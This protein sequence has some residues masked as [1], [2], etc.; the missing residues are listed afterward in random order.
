MP[1]DFSVNL[2]FLF[3]DNKWSPFQGVVLEDYV[4]NVN[5]GLINE[6]KPSVNC[7][8][9]FISSSVWIVTESPSL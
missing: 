7:H 4:N 9:V 3:W 2:R 5:K 8:C 1:S 6:G